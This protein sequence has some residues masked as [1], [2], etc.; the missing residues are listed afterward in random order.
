MVTLRDVTPLPLGVEIDGGMFQS[1]V[2][3]NS[4]IPSEGTQVFTTVADNQRTVE[5]H[6]LQGI[7]VKAEE[8]TSLGKFLLTGIRKAKRGIPQIEVR[9]RVDLDGLLNVTAKDLDTGVSQDVTISRDEEQEDENL[10]DETVRIRVESLVQRVKGLFQNASPDIDSSFKEEV[11]EII[12]RSLDAAA[13]KNRKEML[14]Y[15]VALETVIK[16]LMSI[17]QEQEVGFG[18]A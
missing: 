3:K 6:V 4:P 1:V 11:N 9:F 8:N 13:K 10:S 15:K 5:V 12:D 2:G 14:E 16:E 18:R 17:R 7:G